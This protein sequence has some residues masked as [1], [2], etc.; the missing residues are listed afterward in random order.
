MSPTALVLEQIEAE[1]KVRTQEAKASF[2]KLTSGESVRT[3]WHQATGPMYT[4]LNLA[5][6]YADMLILNQDGEGDDALALG[7]FVDS[8]IIEVG[9]PVLVVPFIGASVPL[10]GKVLVAW[11]G[12]REATRAVN[13]AL[14]LLKAA[15]EV[16]VVCIDPLTTEEEDSPLPGAELCHHL[17][18]HGVRADSNVISSGQIDSCNALLSHASDYGANLIVAGAYGHSRLREL[19]LGGM[20]LNLLKHMTVPVLMSH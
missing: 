14:P 3:N 8:A 12:S 5:A 7:G 11:N 6:R 9:R 15:K 13:D 4:A 17:A 16:Q 19:V 1:Q 18:T 20:T 2:E 10:N